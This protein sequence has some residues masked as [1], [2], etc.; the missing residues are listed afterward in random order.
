MKEIQATHL[1]LLE[2]Q[3]ALEKQRNEKLFNEAT[4]LREQALEKD[5]QD[6]LENEEKDE[7]DDDDEEEPI[8]GPSRQDPSTDDDDKDDPPSG[9][10]PSSGKA[11]TKP[12]NSFDSQSKPPPKALG[13]ESQGNQDVNCGGTQDAAGDKSLP[14]G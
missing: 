6:T 2:K 1:E 11:A 12:T 4:H 13:Q 3:L 10:G 14:R 7:E 9:P 8:E 5:K